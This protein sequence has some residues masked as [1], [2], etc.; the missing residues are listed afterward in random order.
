MNKH[1]LHFVLVLLIVM[2]LAGCGN[3][4]VAETTATE[5]STVST[6]APTAPNETEAEED[7]VYEG[8][9]SSYYIDVVYAEQIGRYHTALSESGTRESISRIT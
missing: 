9:A 1:I 5:Q 7:I 2:L 6:E 4:P 8:D 3:A